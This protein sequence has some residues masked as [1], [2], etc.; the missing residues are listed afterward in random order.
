MVAKRKTNKGAMML[1]GRT[2]EVDWARPDENQFY[3]TRP[4]A[5]EA[6]IR[7]MPPD[8]GLMNP[9]YRTFGVDGLDP[10]GPAAQRRLCSVGAAMNVIEA[11]KTLREIA[12]GLSPQNSQHA[13]VT[14]AVAGVLSIE[15][16]GGCY[17]KS[18]CHPAV[19][20][21]RLQARRDA[22]YGQL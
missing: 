21:F 6:L 10:R 5:T 3:P 18:C 12:D 13:K 16:D 2:G 22:H 17:D 9:R 11:I 20:S 19:R 14:T 15:I 7:A 1:G 4:E 8:V